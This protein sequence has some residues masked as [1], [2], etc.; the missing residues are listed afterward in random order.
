MFIF[1]E[2]KARG[3]GSRRGEGSRFKYRVHVQ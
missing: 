1:S 3:H 2:D